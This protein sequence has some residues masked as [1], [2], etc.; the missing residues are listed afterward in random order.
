MIREIILFAALTGPAYALVAPKG[1]TFDSH[2]QHVVYNADDVVLVHVAI[3]GAT[4]LVFSES[5][6]VLDVASGFSKGWDFANKRNL[7]YIKPK[8]VPGDEGNNTTPKPGL[9]NT[10][11][12]VTTNKR[13]YDI[14]LRLVSGK[15]RSHV[16]SRVQ[17]SYPAETNQA[18]QKRQAQQALSQKLAE[19]PAPRND[20]YTM[21]VG[22][23][24]EQITPAQAYDDGRFTYLKF[25]NNR[26]MPAVFS[27]A[28]DDS[29]SLINTHV[30]GD[31]PDVLVIH[32]V[33]KR[34]VLRLGESVVGVF[35]EAYDSQGLPADTGTTV[36]GV[37]RVVKGEL[38]GE[39]RA[40]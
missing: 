36:P 31:Q 5:E 2:I 22:D 19:K 12:L 8:T 11:L 25:P 16:S 13:L 15:Q 10:N 34:F 38:S 37:E 4:R 28:E 1:S 9:W 27:V 7:L 26:D 21:A 33:A 39:A 35:N 6:E 30:S 18:D 17:Y 40:E 24:S 3:G 20:Q 32:R 29:E 14:D 23:N